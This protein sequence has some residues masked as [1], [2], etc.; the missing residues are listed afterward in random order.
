MAVT[1]NLEPHQAVVLHGTANEVVGQH[2]FGD[3]KGQ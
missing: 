2:A 1:G 3:E